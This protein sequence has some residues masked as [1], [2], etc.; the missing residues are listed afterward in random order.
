M[1]VK[2]RAKKREVKR[3]IHKT[4]SIKLKNT[5]VRSNLSGVVKNLFLFI[6][7]SG[8]SFLLYQYFFKNQFLISLFQIMSMVFGFMATGFLIAFLVL[9]VISIIKTFSK[10]NV[11]LQ[12]APVK[13]KG[14]SK[15]QKE[16]KYMLVE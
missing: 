13:R 7:L 3:V 14:K 12:S 9:L 15:R 8:I 16:I 1:V 4:A 6:I 10:K 2:K 11:S 5:K